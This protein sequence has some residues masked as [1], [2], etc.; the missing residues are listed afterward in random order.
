[1]WI[2]AR[3]TERYFSLMET[4]RLEITNVFNKLRLVKKQCNSYSRYLDTGVTPT[5][6][7]QKCDKSLLVTLIADKQFCLSC[8]RLI[9]SAI[10]DMNINLEIGKG[11]LQLLNRETD[12]FRRLQLHKCI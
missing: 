5:L 6:S 1:M 9:A 12:I 10:S 8:P 11:A 7:I 3:G 2:D 4:E